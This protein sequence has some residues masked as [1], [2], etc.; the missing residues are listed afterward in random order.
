MAGLRLRAVRGH[1]LAG[2]RHY[3]AR[4]DWAGVRE[5]SIGD[6]VL[7]G[8][9]AAVLVMVEAVVRLVPG[10]LGNADSVVDDSFAPGAMADLLEG[11]VFTKPPRLARPRRA[12]GA[13]QRA[14]RAHRAV[15]PRAGAAADARAPSRPAELTQHP[16]HFRGTHPASASCW[17]SH[18]DAGSA[19]L[20]RG[21]AGPTLQSWPGCWVNSSAEGG[22]DDLAGVVLDPGE[23]LGPE[24]RLGVDLVD[25]LGAGRPRREPAVLGGDLEAAD[26]PRRCRARA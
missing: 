18:P 16:G 10:V 2:R 23:V 1:R 24:E 12:R 4:D 15:A 14:P 21:D 6:Y 26:R 5:V 9:E 17:R 20:I 19:R 3:A 25:V 7:A 8:G 13:A 11:P 22:G